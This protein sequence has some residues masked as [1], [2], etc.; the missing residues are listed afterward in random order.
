MSFRR[1]GLLALGALLVTCK[2]AVDPNKGR[3][4]CETD[5]DCGTD[6]ECKKQLTVGAFCFKKGT[7]VAETCNGKDDDC[8]GAIDE[9]F[10]DFDKACTSSKQGVCAPGKLSCVDAAE[11]CVSKVAPSVERCNG[12]DDDCNGKTDETFTL[13]TDSLN[14]GVCGRACPSGTSC[15]LGAC[16]ESNCSDGLDN[17]ADGGIDCADPACQQLTCFTGDDAGY[18][19]GKL[20]DPVDAGADAGQGDAGASD[21]GESDG[22]SVDAGGDGGRF[23]CFPVEQCDDGLDNDQDGLT[24]CADPDCNNRPCIGG[25]VCTNGI[26]PGP[27]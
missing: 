9:T 11:I 1:L 16:R 19:C 24:D 23:F 8:N 21:G 10:P 25:T 2:P 22:G 7:C 13:A 3:F 4:S 17:D 5:A 26:C 14:C 27:G 18:V 20:M 6:F 15:Q 12:L